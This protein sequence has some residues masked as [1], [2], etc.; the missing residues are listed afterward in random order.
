MKTEIIIIS[1]TIVI[2]LY[3]LKR[4]RD[5]KRVGFLNVLYSYETDS[6]RWNTLVQGKRFDELPYE[7][8]ETFVEL[9]ELRISG[10]ITEKQFFD[11]V[12]NYFGVSEFQQTSGGASLVSTASQILQSKGY[13][14]SPLDNFSL[15]NF[16]ALIV[17]NTYQTNTELQPWA[18]DLGDLLEKIVDGADD[19]LSEFEELDLDLIA[20]AAMLDPIAVYRVIRKIQKAPNDEEEDEEETEGK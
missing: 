17:N 16:S 12:F 5:N 20:R 18:S 7:V 2:G 15:S 8:L 10:Q 1:V 4:D 6:V 3:F 19:L 11:V 9:T 14:D 13:I